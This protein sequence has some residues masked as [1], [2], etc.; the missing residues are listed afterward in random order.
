MGHDPLVRLLVVPAYQIHAF[1]FASTHKSNNGVLV[2]DQP[3]RFVSIPS[4]ELLLFQEF[5]DLLRTRQPITGVESDRP[6]NHE[7]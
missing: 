1:W 7:A 2:L 4:Q 3:D 5:I 6:D